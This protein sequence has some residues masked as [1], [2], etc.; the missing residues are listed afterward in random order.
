MPAV[1]KEAHAPE[2]LMELDGLYE[3]ID[4][5][6]VVFDP[7]VS[8]ADLVLAC[9]FDKEDEEDTAE[10]VSS[11]TDNGHA[12]RQAHSLLFSVIKFNDRIRNLET[13]LDSQDTLTNLRPAT[14]K[15][16]LT[17]RRALSEQQATS[18]KDITFAVLYATGGIRV[19]DNTLITPAL[20]FWIKNSVISGGYPWTV[21]SGHGTKT[22][23]WVPDG[24]VLYVQK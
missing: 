7:S 17:Y 1:S 4:Q 23:K 2:F 19:H 18:F 5:R 14:V 24:Y 22:P 15:E 12:G 16:L 9:K 20:C 13:I 8:L 21:T 11:Y 10:F 3:V 6:T